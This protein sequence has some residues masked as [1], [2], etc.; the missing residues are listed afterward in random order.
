[1]EVHL[2]GRDPQLAKFL[3]EGERNVKCAGKERS[4]KQRM[5]TYSA[6]EMNAGII[7]SAH[8]HFI[9]PH[10][11]P[12]C[13]H[14]TRCLTDMHSGRQQ[15]QQGEMSPVCCLAR[16]LWV[17]SLQGPEGSLWVKE[18]EMPERGRKGAQ[19]VLKICRGSLQ[20]FV[21]CACSFL[22]AGK[23]NLCSSIFTWKESQQTVLNVN[24]NYEHFPYH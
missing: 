24:T 21:R 20:G 11:L 9:T 14:C 8:S 5:S 6:V 10:K 18:V 12:E 22:W 19:R 13:R 2:V 3:P 1:M 4:Y 7:K 23:A 16:A 15:E 17:T